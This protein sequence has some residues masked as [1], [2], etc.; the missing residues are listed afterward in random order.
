MPTGGTSAA[1]SSPVVAAAVFGASIEL[2]GTVAAL[3]DVWVR[4]AGQVEERLRAAASWD[5]RFTIA[6]EVLSRRLGARSSVDPEVA[7]AWR[8]TVTSRGQ[9]RVDSL[10]NEAGWGRKRLWSRFR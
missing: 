9:V 7:Y 1:A 5:E 8:R 3:E 2:T 10:A 4:D 6:A